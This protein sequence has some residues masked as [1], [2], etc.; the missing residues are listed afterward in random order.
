[1]K[2]GNAWTVRSVD[3][4]S[5]WEL[6]SC[7]I[8]VLR[9]T[10]KSRLPRSFLWTMQTKQ[11]SR[12]FCPFFHPTDFF[13]WVCDLLNLSMQNTIEL[14]SFKHCV[15]E[16]RDGIT[17]KWTFFMTFAINGG[18]SRVPLGFFN[19]NK[20]KTIWKHSLTAKTRFAHSLSFI[21][22]IVVRYPR[23]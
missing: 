13:T 6:T 23:F 1:M 2:T 9:N 10:F 5:S 22:Y 8:S 18:G 4:F 14:H 11:A 21:L 7:Y 17:K 19:N 20:I 15:C 12:P 3:L 16:I